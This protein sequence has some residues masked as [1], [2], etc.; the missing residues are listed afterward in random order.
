MRKTKIVGHR[1]ASG[2]APEN[3]ILSFQ[4]AIDLGC[5]KTELDVRLSK[6]NQLIVIHDPEVDRIS[7]GQGEVSKMTLS[8]IK[9]LSCPQGE[10][11]PILQEVIDLCKDKIDLLVELKA[12]GTP[13]KVNQVILK[14]QLLSSV[15]VISFDLHLIKEIKELNPKIKTGFLFEED[16][17][18]LWDLAK[19]VPF[20]YI[21]PKSSLVNQKM[22]KRGHDLGLK[23]HAYNVNRKKLATYLI[24]LGVD[25]IGTDFPKLFIGID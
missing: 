7:N 12:E 4:K 15:L 6:D 19:I 23:V 9:E 17:K 8:E 13:E 24:G 14:N 2:Y 3:T 10:K 21:C 20:D 1:G 11:I 22:V 18:R 25:E 5:D 16:N